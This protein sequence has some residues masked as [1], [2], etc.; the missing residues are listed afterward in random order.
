MLEV[1]ELLKI[2]K[3]T[4]ART[5]R[6]SC[7]TLRGIQSVPNELLEKELNALKSSSEEMGEKEKTNG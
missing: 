2:D 5:G 3:N 4:G 1:M 7:S 6:H